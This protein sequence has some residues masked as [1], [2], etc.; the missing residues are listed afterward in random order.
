MG[1]EDLR[2]GRCGDRG[3]RDL[4]MRREGEGRGMLLDLWVYCSA[5]EELVEE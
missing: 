2:E 4:Y 1:V 5:I 3:G